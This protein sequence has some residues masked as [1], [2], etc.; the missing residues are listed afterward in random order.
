MKFSKLTAALG[1]EGAFTEPS[2]SLSSS[3]FLAVKEALNASLVVCIRN[4]DLDVESLIKLSKDF[5]EV[6]ETP[7]VETIS[8]S[9]N[10]VRVS[11]EADEKG[12][13]VY[14]ENNASLETSLC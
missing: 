5:G 8:K 10:V 12:P 4:L 3:D 11:R 14:T 13:C 7:Y 9:L 2:D 6:G 1:V